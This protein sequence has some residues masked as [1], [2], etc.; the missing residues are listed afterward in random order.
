[1]P[2]C[3][4]ATGSPQISSPL[5]PVRHSPTN[6]STAISVATSLPQLKQIHA[7]IFRQNLNWS[8]SLLFHLLISS[9]PFPSGLSYALSVFSTLD[10]PKAHCNKF[11]REL[12][13]SKDPQKALFLLELIWNKGLLIDRYSFPPLLKAASLAFALKEGKI[14]HAL[15]SKLGFDSDPFI[16]TALVRMYGSCGQI[17]EARLVF[18]KM[19]LRDL[20]SWTIMIDG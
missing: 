10:N 9:I 12:S 15:A 7:Q 19:S 8:N 16:Q 18:D 20:V 14:L 2:G 13:R 3:W 6:L 11:F 1:M 4:M 5:L 17:R